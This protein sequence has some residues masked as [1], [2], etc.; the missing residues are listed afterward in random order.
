MV[1]L[2]VYLVG[3]NPEMNGSLAARLE[4]HAPVNI[5]ATARDEPGAMQWLTEQHND[6]DLVIVDLFLRAGSGL[7]VLRRSKKLRHKRHVVV[8]SNFA[9]GELRR[10][11]MALGAAQVFDRTT[12]IDALTAYCANL[13][14]GTALH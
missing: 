5:V 8:V 14:A 9:S 13:A 10:T 12:E 4:R 2:C 1:T 11:C 3:G 6:A 7:G